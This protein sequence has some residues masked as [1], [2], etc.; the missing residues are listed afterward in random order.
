MQGLLLQFTQVSFRNVFE[1]E[2]G[3]REYSVYMKRDTY[4]VGKQMDISVM[5]AQHFAPKNISVLGPFINTT[6]LHKYKNARLRVNHKASSVSIC[7]NGDNLS[8]RRN[9]ILISYGKDFVVK[10][11]IQLKTLCPVF[12]PSILINIWHRVSRLLQ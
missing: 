12:D 11:D 7:A 3:K 8:R 6:N 1:I 9:T 2:K 4:L 5:H 10:N